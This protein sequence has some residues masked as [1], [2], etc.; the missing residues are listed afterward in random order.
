[1]VWQKWL[2]LPF[3]LRKRRTSAFLGAYAMPCD[4]GHRVGKLSRKSKNV[5]VGVSIL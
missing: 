5:K 2:N 1:M 3:A 4:A